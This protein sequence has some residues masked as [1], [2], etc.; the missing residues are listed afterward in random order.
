LKQ[1]E[2]RNKQNPSIKCK[3]KTY[4]TTADM[5]ALYDEGKWLEFEKQMEES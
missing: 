4:E 1:N 5:L 2:E 3:K